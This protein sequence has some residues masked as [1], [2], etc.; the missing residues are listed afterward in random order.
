MTWVVDE[1]N[2]SLTL[3]SDSSTFLAVASGT[4][5]SNSTWVEASDD[6]YT[7]SVTEKV[8]IVMSRTSTTGA[9][10]NATYQV[11]GEE[12]PVWEKIFLGEEP[13]VFDATIGGI[14]VIILLQAIVVII[15]C[16]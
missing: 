7:V 9:S 6:T 13:W 5:R 12:Y 10:F 11:I 15:C 16:R 1:S 3:S 14:A 4:S 8:I 2:I